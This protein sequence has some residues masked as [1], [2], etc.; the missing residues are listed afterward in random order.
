MARQSS[1]IRM[2][3]VPLSEIKTICLAFFG[4]RDQEIVI[5]R[6]TQPA[7]VLIGFEMEE[8]WFAY[9]LYQ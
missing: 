8:D 1:Q 9:R 4:R 2:K 5:T 3:E 6:P 7:G